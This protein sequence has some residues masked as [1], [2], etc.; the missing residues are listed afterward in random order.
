MRSSLETSS[1]RVVLLASGLA[2]FSA[3]CGS[4]SGTPNG[5]GGHTADAGSDVKGTGG[6]TGTGGKTD[7]GGDVKADAG[8]G[9]MGTGGKVDAGPDS[10]TGG[11]VVDSGVDTGPMLNPPWHAYLPLVTATAGVT[12]SR[13]VEAL[14]S[15]KRERFVG[16]GPWHI[17]VAGAIW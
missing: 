16:S 1:F 10:G 6:V 7:A 9:G 3:A 5:A 12:E 14:A 4:S 17:Q 8:T 15:V 2:I 13:I 11:M